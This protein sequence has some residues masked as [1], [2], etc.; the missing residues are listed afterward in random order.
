MTVS[1]K[2]RAGGA[3]FADS[4]PDSYRQAMRH[5][6]SPVAVVTYSTA[7]GLAGITC[8]AICSATTEPPTIIVCL[9]RSSEAH[10]AISQAGSFAVNF[11]SDE[12]HEIARAFSTSGNGDVAPFEAW[13]W[14]SGETRSP[15]LAGAISSFD[16]RICQETDMGA[17]RVFFGEILAVTSEPGSGLLYRD[18]YFRRVAS[19]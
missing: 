17:H 8:T 2:A 14:T 6:V 4:L 11:L 16:C 7:E 3:D 9:N 19:E 18:G 10:A 12:Q 15:M 1:V 13:Q 5:V